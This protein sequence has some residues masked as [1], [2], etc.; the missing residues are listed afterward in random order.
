MKLKS[1]LTA[2][3]AVVLCSAA[4]AATTDA[5]TSTTT[6]AAAPAN[7][8]MTAPKTQDTPV[9]MGKVSYS[10]GVDLGENFKSQG[11]NID[12]NMF[13][14]GLMDGYTN[15]KLVMTKQ[16]MNDVLVAFQKQMQA[17]Q[18][19]Q[20]AAVSDKNDKDGQA[21]LAANKAKQGIVTTASGLQ[22]KVITA[23]TG[24]APKDSDTVTVDYEG[25]FLNGQVF[26]SSYQRG[27]PVTFPVSE[28]IPG[29]V[30]ALKLMQPG[31]TYEIYVPSQLAYGDHGLGNVIGPKQTLMFKVHLISIKP[32]A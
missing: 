13:Q 18:Q 23:G 4:N 27:K 17:K 10:I 9:D 6:Q 28:V 2:I 29:W 31:A 14:K 7:T 11:I 20:L 30:E 32:A 12:P 22:Y 1:I 3:T 8:A 26:D 15:G 21:F 16:E 5:T 24:A 25:K 19:A